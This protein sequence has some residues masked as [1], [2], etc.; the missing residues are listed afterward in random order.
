[1]PDDL[2]KF[3]DAMGGTPDPR[4]DE[5]Q[6][7][8]FARDIA[9]VRA[10]HSFGVPLLAGTDT[11][12]PYTYP[13]FSLHEE[14]QL[15]VSAGLSPTE[16]LCTATLRAAEF[17]GVQHDFGSVEEGKVANLLLLEANPADDIRNTQKIRAVVLRGKFLDR[18]N[19]DKLLLREKASLAH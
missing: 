1:M 12:N 9:I 18:E 5:I 13:G 10:M 8:L 14:L 4:N 6:L 15:L 17:L 3:W 2:R 16:V 7:R 11:P 19:L